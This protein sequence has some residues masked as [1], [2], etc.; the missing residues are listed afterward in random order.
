MASGPHTSDMSEGEDSVTVDRSRLA[1]RTDTLSLVAF[2]FPI[3]APLVLYYGR[4]L[5]Q[6]GDP[7]GRVAI[8]RAI[9]ALLWGL[10]LAWYL[11]A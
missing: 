6:R 5:Q 2:A 11:T 3:L 1:S 7:F 8:G 4:R 10:F 9:G